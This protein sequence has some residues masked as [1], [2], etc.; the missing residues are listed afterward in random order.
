MI[1]PWNANFGEFEPG[2]W[3]PITPVPSVHI[4]DYTRFHL[5]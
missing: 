3:P 4:P 5:I 2:S 1:G